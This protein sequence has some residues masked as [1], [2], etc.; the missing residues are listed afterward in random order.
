MAQHR[1]N[2]WRTTRSRVVYRNPWIA[3]REDQVI[4]PDGAEGIYGV[5]EIPA[6]CGI[7][8]IR[9]DGQIALV[10]QWRY[11]HDRYS[12]EIPTGGSEPG[13][14]PLAAARRELAEET[15]LTGGTWSGLGTID[16]SNG[17]TTDVAHI[18]LARQL[19]AGPA[20]EA[21]GEPVELTWMPFE[22]SVAAVLA[23][24]ITESVSVAGILKARLL[25]LA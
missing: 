21:G 8:A 13:E 20:A 11:V 17:V 6:S 23:G 24:E 18:F 14:T 15:G 12:V 19:T 3:V 22:A 25:G 16:N 1:V 5:V 2:P 9:E 4:R 7:V 10:G